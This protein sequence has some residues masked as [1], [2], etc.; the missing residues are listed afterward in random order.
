MSKKHLTSD[1]RHT[2]SVMYSEGYKQKEIAVVLKKCKSVISRE[3]SRNSNPKTGKYHHLYAHDMA[4]IRKERFRQQRK[5]TFYL[6]RTIIFLL[7]EGYSPEQ[8]SG[9]LKLEGKE[10]VSHETIYKMIRSDKKAGGNLYRY[11]RHQL[12]KR[13]RIVYKS[14]AITEKLALNSVLQ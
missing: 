1:Q 14:P 5:M 9:R 11:C 7:Q 8:I 12:K 10:T 6:K 3:I 2:I 4:T 13:K